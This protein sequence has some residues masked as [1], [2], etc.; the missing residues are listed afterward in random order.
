MV[1]I[2][3]ILKLIQKNYHHILNP[4]TGYCYDNGLSSVT[5]I[6]KSSLQGD[7]LSTVCFALGKEKGLALLNSIKNRFRM[8][9]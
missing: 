3:D 6:S 1:R 4:S 2:K 9:Y 5:I 7:A 8:F